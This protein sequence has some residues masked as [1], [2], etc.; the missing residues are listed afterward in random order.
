MGGSL[1]HKDSEGHSGVI[2]PDL[3]QR[4][5][6]GRGI[7]HSERNDQSGTDEAV[8]LVQMWV[9]PDETETTPTYEQLNLSPSDLEGRLAVIASGMPQHADETA[10][11]I[12]N[13]RA[14]FHVARLDVGVSVEVPDA[15]FVHLYLPRGEVVLEDAGTLQAGDAVR[16]T[17]AGQRRVSA[18]VPSE[19][20]AWEMH[21]SLASRS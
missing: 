2:Y 4:M 13:R 20:L 8:D 9:V 21:A 5:S 15:P 6:A 17:A 19:V 16:L 14:A 18:L 3:A 11:H 7:W 12:R 1:V 10:I